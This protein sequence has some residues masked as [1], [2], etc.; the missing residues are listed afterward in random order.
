MKVLQVQ[1]IIQ[2]LLNVSLCSV[3]LADFEFNAEDNPSQ[4]EN[5]VYPFTET[6]D[7]IFK[8]YVSRLVLPRLQAGLHYLNLTRP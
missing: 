7:V 4:K 3:F 6:R 2:N 1:G 8:Y 5:N